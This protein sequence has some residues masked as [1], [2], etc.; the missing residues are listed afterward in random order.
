MAKGKF[1]RGDGSC[2][3]KDTVEVDDRFFSRI[4]VVVLECGSSSMRLMTKL[5]VIVIGF[6][7]NDGCLVEIGQVS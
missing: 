6:L 7:G 2:N 5:E 3:A 1:V 4:G